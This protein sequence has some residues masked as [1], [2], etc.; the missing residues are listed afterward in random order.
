MESCIQLLRT[1]PTQGV[2]H[3]RYSSQAASLHVLHCFSQNFLTVRRQP[4]E[5]DLN[6]SIASVKK[7]ETVSVIAEHRVGCYLDILRFI[8]NGKGGQRCGLEQHSGQP[9]FLSYQDNIVSPHEAPLEPCSLEQTMAV[10]LH[11]W[12]MVPHVVFLFMVRLR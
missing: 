3:L 12:R 5:R 11:V 10:H 9:P 6:S 1:L 8:G 2:K 4:V 7:I